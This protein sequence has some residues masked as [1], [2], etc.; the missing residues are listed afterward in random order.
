[1]SLMNPER[2]QRPDGDCCC[3]GSLR[4]AIRGVMRICQ[5]SH[6]MPSDDVKNDLS[7]H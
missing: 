2:G 4:E 5:Q 7:R 3:V 6:K 1:M